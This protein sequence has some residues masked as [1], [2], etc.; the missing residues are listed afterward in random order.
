MVLDAVVLLLLG[1]QAGCACDCGCGLRVS[2]GQTM[3]TPC[4]H[5]VC[6]K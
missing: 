3:C 4:A 5:G 2:S 1:F 6:E